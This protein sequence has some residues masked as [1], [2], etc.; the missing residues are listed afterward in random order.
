MTSLRFDL[1]LTWKIL[2]FSLL[3]FIEQL[4][5]QNHQISSKQKPK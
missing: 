4:E 2:N 3:Q 1:S 5:F